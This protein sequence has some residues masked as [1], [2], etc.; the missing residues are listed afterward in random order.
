MA[1]RNSTKTA[2]KEA[3]QNSEPRIQTFRSWNG[4]N[5]AE[6]APEVDP[7]STLVGDENVAGNNDNQFLQTSMQPTFLHLQ[8]NVITTNQKCL[9]V[10]YPT[11]ILL[12]NV[13]VHP[14]GVACMIDRYLLF[15]GKYNEDSNQ[16]SLF[17]ID[18]L[19]PGD[20]PLEVWDGT[21]VD[22]PL[23]GTESLSNEESTSDRVFGP[24]SYSITRIG[25]FRDT[26]I[27]LAKDDKNNHK[28]LIHVIEYNQDGTIKFNNEAPY[29]DFTPAK[30][31]P[32]PR[33]DVSDIEF[34][35]ERSTCKKLEANDQNAVIRYHV[36]FSVVNNFGTTLCQE[37]RCVFYTDVVPEEMTSQKAI[38]LK[39]HLTDAINRKYLDSVQGI[40]LYYA[41]DDFVEM[42]FMGHID[43]DP[44]N[45]PEDGIYS[46]TWLGGMQDVSVWQDNS[47]YE[48]TE[49][50]TA[51]VDAEYFSAF[52]GRLYFWG[53]S[54]KQRLYIGGIAGHELSVARGYGGAWI[55]VDAGSTSEIMNCHR[56][57]TQ[58]GAAC[59]TVLCN[60]T[61][62][63][64]TK[65]YNIVE[66]TTTLTNELTTKSFFAEEVSNV[67]G[68]VSHYGSGTWSDGLYSLGRYG[69]TITTSTMEYNTQLK[70]QSVSDAIKPLFTDLP[71]EKLKDARVFCLDE[72]IYISFANEDDYLDNVIL[73][74]DIGLKAWYTFSIDELFHT[75]EHIRDFVAVD[76][77]LGDEG[78][79]VLTDKRI[80]FIPLTGK[81]DTL[82]EMDRV[83]IET[84]SLAGRIPPSATI[85]LCQA[86]FRFDWFV[87]D[88]EIS[89]EGVDYYGRPFSCKKRVNH[90]AIEYKLP[91]YI[92]IDRMVE[93]YRVRIVGNAQFR[94]THVLFKAFTQSNKIDV[95]YGF[96]THNWHTT[97]HHGREDQHH[98]VRDYNNLF[99]AIVP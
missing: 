22:M 77:V 68:C 99:R 55:D 65:R 96:D 45:I 85:F 69:L 7:F 92:R 15:A 54:N 10:R 47:M 80:M 64:Q 27:I 16:T 38:V 81:R 66:T 36:T 62:S 73:C 97:H 3:L 94:L 89:I 1:K 48:P 4:I 29:L 93:T 52:D 42:S 39:V 26:L 74:Y 90:T 44:K 49:N 50:S 95:V 37:K 63:T 18:T 59:I 13:G 46:F 19:S 35:T 11:K 83:C 20:T 67:I 71:A 98:T 2:T 12:D 56:F 8:N 57:K 25:R 41:I 30:F 9:E 61:N 31:I 23:G 88:I 72:V 78:I 17:L 79:G 84:H 75:D 14:T 32:N 34:D 82:A 43:V 60:N 6:E 91:V 87:G 58:G 76:S 40:D 51:G 33:A 28:I 86:E 21:Y 53:G 24:S 70:S 5:I